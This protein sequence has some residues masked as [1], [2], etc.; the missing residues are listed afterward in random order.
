MKIFCNALT[1]LLLIASFTAN[2][3]ATK[4]SLLRGRSALSAPTTR[5]YRPKWEADTRII[6]DKQVSHIAPACTECS[7]DATLPNLP[8]QSYWIP[9]KAG[10]GVTFEINQMEMED[11]KRGDVFADLVRE[12]KDFSQKSRSGWYPESLIQVGEPQKQGSEIFQEVRVYPMQ[13]SRDGGQY[14]KVINLTYTLTNIPYEDNPPSVFRFYAPQSVLKSGNWHKM[15]I[16]QDGIYKL[17]YSFFQANNIDISNVNPATIRIFGNGAGMV[18]QNNDAPRYDD[19]HETP[20]KVVTQNPQTFGPGDYVLFYGASPHSWNYN[21]TAQRFQHTFNTYSDSNFYYLNVGEAQGLRIAGT[22]AQSATY[23]ATHS[24]NYTFYEIDKANRGASGRYWMGDLFNISTT[25]RRYAFYV[26]DVKSGE[27]VKVT[28]RVTARGDATTTFSIQLPNQSPVLPLAPNLSGTHPNYYANPIQST[29]SVPAQFITNDSLIITLNYNRGAASSSEGF[30]DF[31]E[32]DYVQALDTRNSD[33][34]Y[35]SLVDN[36]G[37]GSVADVS[38]AN[39]NGYQ[40]WDITASAH[41]AEVVTNFNGS[42]ANFLTYADSIKRFVAF[43][44]GFRAPVAVKRIAN[45]DLHGLPLADYIMIAPAD[46]SEQANR[47]AAFHRETLGHTVHVVTPQQIYN[48]FSGGKL[49]VSGIRDFLKM[50]HDRSQGQ[51]PKYVLLFGDGT[52]DYKNINKGGKNFV[53][54]YQSREFISQTSSYTSDD[55]YVMLSDTDGRWGEGGFNEPLD[56]SL[57]DAAIGRFPVETQEEA[58]IMVDK[59]IAYGTGKMELGNWKSRVVLVADYKEGEGDLH[60][61]DADSYTSIIQNANPC[62]NIDKIYFDNYAAQI[63]ASGMTFPDARRD[64]LSRLD[65]GAL[66]LNWTGHGNQT[67]WSN[68]FILQNGDIV[69]IKNPGRLPAIVTATC[70][71]GRYDDPELKTGAELFALNPDGGA[72][73]MFTTVRLVFTGPNQQLNS[74]FYRYVFQ[75]DTTNHRMPTMGEVMRNAKNRMYINGDINSRNFTLMGDPGLTLAYPKLNAQITAI[76]GKTVVSTQMDSIASLQVVEVKGKVTD[77]NGIVQ[78]N[79]NGDMEV[80]VFDKPNLFVT[81]LIKFGFYWQ[82]NRLFNGNVSIKN[83]EFTFKFVVPIDIS[84]DQGKGKFSMYFSNNDIDGAGCYSN[85]FVGGTASNVSPDKIGPDVSLYINDENWVEGGTTFPD[86]DIFALVSD[87][88]G[89]NI[90]NTSIGHEISVI[91]NGDAAKPLILNEYY[92]AKKDSYTEGNVRYKMRDLSPGEYTIKMRVWDVANNSSEAQ[93]RF[94]LSENAEMAL[95]QVLNYPNPFTTHTTF[96]IGHN[97]VGKNLKAQVK[98]FTISGQIVKT[99]DADF[100]AEGNYFRDL[101][102]DGLDEYGDKIG[103]GT[104]VYQVSLRDIDTGKQVT[105]FEKLVILR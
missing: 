43:K 79:Y 98:I 39:A 24:R 85:L 36:V 23:T 49:D 37:P 5:V 3:Q 81:R 7:Y 80:T 25:S 22:P 87:P 21:P 41:P 56:K 1:V 69:D 57:M 59:V 60:M 86:P 32:L 16:L 44:G 84:Y 51:Y 54:T 105:K 90:T 62:V 12:S 92:T 67:A 70:E 58:K 26:P 47:L 61:S 73:A 103:R 75:Y 2:G 11:A 78:S 72:I 34:H 17:D 20:I 74:H 40:I 6:T 28:I 66:I 71:F 76:N 77:D 42:T 52:Y 89:I 63:T 88:S 91:T 19:L 35:F 30:L 10:E 96:F 100:Y 18:P 83:G 9:V 64:L 46:F 38:L 65:E 53:P 55:F 13:V 14:R 82:K 27:N 93:T 8:Y 33:F 45:Q 68:S 102:W 99:L 15:A 50:F 97:Q 4:Q 48:E 104:Y 95:S 94:I 101:E 31:I 29:Y